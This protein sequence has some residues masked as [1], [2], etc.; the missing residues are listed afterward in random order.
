[1]DSVLISPDSTEVRIGYQKGY[2]FQTFD[3][4]GVELVGRTATW[5][6]TNPAVA[7]VDPSTG[8]VTGVAVGVTTVTA[9]SEGITDDAIISVSIAPVDSVVVVPDST[10]IYLGGETTF[11]ATTLDSLGAVLTGRDVTWSISDET[12]AT[13]DPTT[14]LASAVG[15][16]ITTVTATSEGITDTGI[17]VVSP[18]P[19]DSV[20]VSPDSTEIRVGGTTSYTAATFDSIG[21]A[22]LGR[23]VTW[24]TADPAIAT[25]DPATGVVTGVDAGVTT[26]IATSEGITDSAIIAVSLRPVDSVLVSPDSSEVRT[27]YQ[28]TYTAAVF[29]STGAELTGRAVTWSS[30]D[31]AIATID[32]ATGIVTGVSV[33]V[34][35]LT[36]TSEGITDQAIIAVTLSPVDSVQVSPDSTEIRVGG[37]TTYAASVFDSTGVALTGR[38]VTWSILDAGV[39]SIDPATGEVT[40]LTPGVT[41]VTATSEGIT[42]DAILT[43]SPVPVDSVLVSPDSTEI[44]VGGTTAY[45]A[46]T[47]DSIG[48]ALLGREV[49]WSTADPAIATVDPA[50]GVVTGVDA[51]VT[52]VIATS[53]G[54]TDSAIIAVSLRPVDSVLVSPDS[55]D[56]AVG[57]STA[58]GA[59]VFDS[60]GAELTGRSVTWSSANPAIA[61]VDEATGVVTGVSVGLTTLTATSEGITDDAI[62]TVSQVPVDSVLVSPDS[63][64]VRIGYT[65]TFTAQTFDA[66]GGL[67]AGRDL[68]WA[69]TDPAIA[70]VDPATG[71]VTGVA[72]GTT[73]I[74]ATS[75]GVTDAAIV[76]VSPPL[77]ATVVISPDSTDLTPGSTTTLTAAVLDSTGLA[78]TGRT[79]TWT[80]GDGAVAAIDAATGQVTAGALGATTVTAT[81]EGVSDDAIVTVSL[82]GF[83]LVVDSDQAGDRDLWLVN[84]VDG[85]QLALTSGTAADVD[86]DW[87]P[88]GTQ[89]AF[90]RNGR[91]TLVDVATGTVGGPLTPANN[92]AAALDW[93][94][95]GSLIAYTFGTGADREIWTVAPEGGR[96]PITNNAAEDADPA[97]SPDGTQIVFSSRRDGDAEIYVMNADGQVQ[98]RI[99]TVAGDDVAPKFSPDGT[100][101]VFASTR[102]GGESEIYVMN[103]D[104]TN[105]VRLTN[106]AGADTSPAW[107]PDGSQIY[108]V[109]NRDGNAEVY[110][111]DANGGNPSRVTN[112]AAS[113][114]SPSVR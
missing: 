66:T 27:G 4:L 47:F 86:A 31:P 57:G 34:T 73:T 96:T 30:T 60:T 107:S 77:V 85:V 40:G 56:V 51:G 52:T 17:L 35:T 110:V 9:T 114:A 106:A 62:V 94:P 79:V 99:T 88:D 24:S 50:T 29:D 108:F 111:M 91:V 74:T 33:G 72:T 21:G 49:T 78:L 76:S 101:I 102:D 93:S 32:P 20:L 1:V 15:L 42:D 54:I 82:T 37:A 59:A 81:S 6:T 61:T 68:T 3:S 100:R 19:V 16:G 36:A 83:R 70:T 48:G 23:E 7:T 92:P 44:R 75:E 80:S 67:L 38:T 18:V 43:V 14:G 105:A 39:A 12:V 84:P 8:V 26:V 46:A 53:E 22:L 90:A 98:T 89:V 28:K 10:E 41:T 65:K 64:E 71:V 63:V 109:S 45:T 69:S 13:I 113:E 103:A 11:A 58:Y 97:W 2:T 55:A 104:G 95:D 87:S 25:V 5:S 112:T